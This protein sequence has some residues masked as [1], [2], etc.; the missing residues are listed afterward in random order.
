MR[1]KNLQFEKFTHKQII[2]WL[3]RE[4]EKALKEVEDEGPGIECM[5]HFEDVKEKRQY[6]NQHI[7]LI[8]IQIRLLKYILELFEE[9]T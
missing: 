7:S 6:Y 5:D 8:K 3:I 9:Y 2:E 1:Q 4:K